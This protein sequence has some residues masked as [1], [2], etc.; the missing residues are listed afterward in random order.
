[1]L[2]HEDLVVGEHLRHVAKG[3]VFVANAAI[4]ALFAH[5]ADDKARAA[6]W[7]G[8]RDDALDAAR[9]ALARA[10]G[11]GSY[12]LKAARWVLTQ[13]AALLADMWN[14]AIKLDLH[15]SYQSKRQGFG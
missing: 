13:E 6:G 7:R 11:G 8:G 14:E 12:M 10:E 5:V 1:M 2:P 15:V 3:L 9:A 4:E